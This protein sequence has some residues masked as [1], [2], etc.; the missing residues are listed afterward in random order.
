[1]NVLSFGYKYGLPLDADMVFDVRFLPNPN[2]VD[3]LREL[4]GKD[5]NVKEFVCGNEETKRFM[6]EISGFLD[7]LLPNYTN[8]GKVYLTIGVG[9]TGGRHRSVAIADQVGQ[10]LGDTNYP[11][12]VRHRDIAK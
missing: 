7:Y 2:Y 5:E 12:R 1:M 4:T 11:V 8:E 3:D 9:C 10:F 6:S